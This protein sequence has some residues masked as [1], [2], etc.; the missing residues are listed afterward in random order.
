MTYAI[1]LRVD[2]Q[3]TRPVLVGEDDKLP[4]EK[5]VRWRYVARTDDH[6]EALRV[7]EVLQQRC[8][9]DEPWVGPSATAS[10]SSLGH[11]LR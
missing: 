1:L 7:A 6:A 8:D 2:A 10:A 3:G 4:P 5:G 9:V 11:R